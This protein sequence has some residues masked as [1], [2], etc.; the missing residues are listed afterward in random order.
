M[1]PGVASQSPHPVSA[2]NNVPMVKLLP[3]PIFFILATCALFDS[4]PKDSAEPLILIQ[5]IQLDISEPSGLSLDPTSGLLYCV[6]DP[7]SNKVFQMDLAGEVQII[8]AFEGDDLEGI[9]YDSRDNSM[10]V[11]E[12]RVRELVHLDE[13]GHELSRSYIDF[14]AQEGN[15]GLEGI[16]LQAGTNDFFAVSEKNPT[17]IIQ[18]DSNLTITWRK[19]LSFAS[20]FSAI[21]PGRNQNEYIILSHEDQH[22]YEWS[23]AA[24]LISTY[25]FDVKQAEGVAYDS[26]SELIYIVCDAESKLYTY[27]FPALNDSDN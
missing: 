3:L 26:T 4:R 23:K 20:D 1:R 12:E 10:W 9:C 21:C 11:V 6:N 17:M 15:N 22:L 18:I 24:G 7:P 2:T 16:C 19:E 25:R 14:S 27:K 5:E 8:Y 13:Q